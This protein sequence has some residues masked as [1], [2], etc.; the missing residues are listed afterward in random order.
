MLSLVS[1]WLT[2][3]QDD[4]EDWK[5][6]NE[7]WDMLSWIGP[8][9]KNRGVFDQAFA[10]A[11]GDADWLTTW[12]QEGG[13]AYMTKPERL[14]QLHGSVQQAITDL[15]LQPPERG[16]LVRYVQAQK[17]NDQF[18]QFVNSELGGEFFDHT[19]EDGIVQQGTYSYYNSLD[20][21]QKKAFRGDFPE[22]YDKVQA[23]YDMKELFQEDHPVWADY[24]G[25]DTE[26]SVSLPTSTTTGSTFTPP[27]VRPPATR[28]SGGGGG[29]G[30][31]AP[32][33]DLPITPFQYSSQ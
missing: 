29:G 33:P 23:Y 30:G 11:G 4:P 26:P 21:E 24:Y 25:F 6:R 10:N 12:Y 32:Q 28:R 14:A 17:E 27:S 3:G 18:Q 22:E 1:L 9:N 19:D 15:G 13:K 20:R 2:Q 5:T 16:E 8:G 31:S 7:I